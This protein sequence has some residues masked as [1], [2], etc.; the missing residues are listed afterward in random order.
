MSAHEDVQTVLT[1]P[2]S[3]ELR[4][5][6]A[7]L[8]QDTRLGQ[9][10]TNLII[11]A[12]S[13][14]EAHGQVRVSVARVDSEVEITVED[15]GPG[16]PE[17]ALEKIFQRFYTD[18]PNQGFGQNSG[19]GLSI[20]RQIILAHRGRIWAENRYRNGSA[21]EG[22]REAIGAKFVIRLPAET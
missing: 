5:D 10:L 11:N 13:F 3:K 7:V 22:E 17:H 14:S 21:D 4:K 1:T 12:K 16:I 2:I 20:S 15:D 9:V 8:G 6:Y 19:L 18:R